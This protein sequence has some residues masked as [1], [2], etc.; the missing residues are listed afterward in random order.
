MTIR[1]YLIEAE[2]DN[3]NIV[4]SVHITKHLNQLDK[5][6]TH[7]IHPKY[8]QYNIRDDFKSH[9]TIFQTDNNFTIIDLINS[10][11][12]ED[13]IKTGWY[14]LPPSRLESLITFISPFIETIENTNTTS[15]GTYQCLTCQQIFKNKRTL[16][17]HQCQNDTINK[18]PNCH[19]S[20][21][22]MICYHNH[23]L[24]CKPLVC[25]SCHN[26]FSSKQSLD[27]HIEKGCGTFPCEKCGK[28]FLSKYKI[29][30]HCQQKHQFTPLV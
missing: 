9:Q 14:H 4:E 20:F 16:S 8:I 30:Q 3:Y 10:P 26:K 1:L 13:K 28:T 29:I 2:N 18:C 23:I 15:Q 12:K 11:F 21:K 25:E 19:K 22:S 7:T 5:Y 6:S 24:K 27:K 17:S